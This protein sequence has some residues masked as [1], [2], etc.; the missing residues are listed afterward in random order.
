MERHP[1]ESLEAYDLFLAAQDLNRSADIGG[2]LERV[3]EAL[4]IDPLFARA[5][6]LKADIHGGLSQ[7]AAGAESFAAQRA[8]G[9]AAALR[10]NELD[11]QL[12]EAR[13]QLVSD[14]DFRREW[15]EAEALFRSGFETSSGMMALWYGVHLMSVGNL[16][17]ANEVLAVARL[18][19]PL[20]QITRGFH[21]LGLA[22]DGDDQRAEAEYARGTAV[23]GGTWFGDWYVSMARLDPD[24]TPTA[25][26]VP[27]FFLPA[28]PSGPAIHNEMRQHLASPAEGLT[29]LRAIYATSEH[30]NGALIATGVCAGYFGD[31]DLAFE[32][33]AEASLRNGQNVLHFWLPALRGV[34]QT[35]RFEAFAREIGLVDFW[36][37][38][39]WPA[40]CRP[41]GGEDFV[42]S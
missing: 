16:D 30:G 24:N 3:D 22:L 39:E 26:E 8:A 34:R 42:C 5:W 36:N 41:L 29:R 21:L 15:A 4:A 31:T 35:P 10:A 13:A 37:E 11:P 40:F 33:I 20:D 23:F 28:D 12:I 18:V 7:A 14:A 9:I 1:T 32:A 38:F 27:E 6:A 25:D 19:D 17:E 2:A